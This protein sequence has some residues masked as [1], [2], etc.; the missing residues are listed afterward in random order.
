MQPLVAHAATDLGVADIVRLD[1]PAPTVIV[2]S[3]TQTNPL[4]GGA[5]PSHP[6]IWQVTY[7]FRDLEY[8]IPDGSGGQQ[9][10]LPDF[11]NVNC[12][13]SAG[14]FSTNVACYFNPEA[15]GIFALTN[16]GTIDAI[17]FT[18]PEAST[19]AMMV[20]GFAGLGFAAHRCART[21]PALE[22]V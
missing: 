20:I 19:W 16:T 8:S 3:P 15:P 11:T 12:R 1:P 22:P 7:W 14:A 10:A 4:P 13:S 18:V 2:T 5:P 6:A 21:H 17:R 9:F